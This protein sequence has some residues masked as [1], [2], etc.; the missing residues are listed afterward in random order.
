MQE[1]RARGGRAPELDEHAL[2]RREALLQVKH[3]PPSHVRARH[4]TSALRP[5]HTPPHP[6]FRDWSNLTRLNH[7]DGGSNSNSDGWSNWTA[8]EI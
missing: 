6:R 5:S 7:S 8:A 2:L 4:T 3:L 1:A